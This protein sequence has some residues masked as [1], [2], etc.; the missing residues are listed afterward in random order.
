MQHSNVFFKLHIGFDTAHTERKKSG[1]KKRGKTR[2]FYHFNFGSARVRGW[3]FFC[4]PH[5]DIHRANHFMDQHLIFHPAI[6]QYIFL[7]FDTCNRT[8]FV[9]L[10]SSILPT[11]MSWQGCQKIW[12]TK[13]K[14][15]LVTWSAKIQPK[16][17]RIRKTFRKQGFFEF[18]CS[19]LMVFHSFFNFG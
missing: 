7:N 14:T 17:N 12:K 6:S 13:L 8:T 5:T 4:P 16:L 2:V 15:T 11:W 9:F 10:V 1:D 3:E 18:F 19:I